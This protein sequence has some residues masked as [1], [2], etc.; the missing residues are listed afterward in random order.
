MFFSSRLILCEGQEDLAYLESYLALTG[1]L[2][3]YRRQGIH[4]VPVNG[5]SQLLEPLL[6]AQEL[7]LPTFVIFDGDADAPDKYQHDHLRNN[8][9]LHQALKYKRPKERLTETIWGPNFVSWKTDLGETVEKDISEETRKKAHEYARKEAGFL[10]DARK[11]SLYIG[12][13]LDHVIQ[14]EPTIDCLEQLCKTLLGD[15]A[16]LGPQVD[17]ADSK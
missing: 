4:I 12:Y 15:K 11:N 13:F 2:D 10:K 14:S 16:W 3:D 17:Q 9:R 6:V 7:Q 5:K 1:R 8:D